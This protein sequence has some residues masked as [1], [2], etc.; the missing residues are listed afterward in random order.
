[1]I[2]IRCVVERITYQNPENGYSVLKCRVKDYSDLVPVVGN[3]LDANVGSVLLVEGN[4]KVD[5]KYGRQFVAENWEETLPATV[6]GM[7]KYLG[8][9]LIKGVGPKF[10]KK[11]VQK[12]GVDT[13]TVIEDNVDLLIEID[14]IGSK[15]VQM[16][17]E[18][19]L[20][21]KEVKN[22]MRDGAADGALL[23][24]KAAALPAQ[25]VIQTAVMLRQI[26]QDT[27]VTQTPVKLHQPFGGCHIDISDAAG[28]HHDLVGVL[29]DGGLDLIAE[30][31]D[32]GKEEIAAEAVDH[33][34]FDRPCRSIALQGIKIAMTRD[35][36]DKSCGR[37]DGADRGLPEGEHDTDDDA[38]QCSEEQYTEKSKEKDQPF[39]AVGVAQL[40][41]RPDLQD[42]D[43]RGGHDAGEH[44]HRQILKKRGTEHE[45]QQH[46]EAG[47]YG[48]QLGA[49]ALG[50]RY[51]AAGD[52]AVDG[53]GAAEGPGEIHGT[54][55]QEFGIV[56][57]G[58]LIFSCIIAGC[59]QCLG[60]DH[61]SDAQRLYQQIRKIG[62]KA[63]KTR[64]GKRQSLTGSKCKARKYGLWK[65]GGDGRQHLDAIPVQMK[66]NLQKSAKEHH[67]HGHG[68]LRKESFAEQDD[69]DGSH[70]KR[71]GK[72][73]EQRQLPH[74][75]GKQGD[76]LTRTR[77]ASKDF[78][79][80][81]RMMVSPTPD[82]KPPITGMEM[83]LTIRP[84][85]RK[86]STRN[87]RAVS[88]VMTGTSRRASSDSA[89]KPICAST[90]P[91][92]TAGMAS[93]P[94]TNC[95]EVVSRP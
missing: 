73:M 26:E 86:Y 35:A 18:S 20:K 15:R 47:G 13:F 54:V 69:Q 3:L 34:I 59:Q 81:I 49:H 57:E 66:E 72:G 53:A 40:A 85:F 78:G 56:I 6:Y 67:D 87:Q 25:P 63:C 22:I 60:H 27:A 17:A 2:K 64:Q 95:L 74:D 55:C 44:R 48:H 58:I 28:I 92:I 23:D 12:F 94:T 11:I 91:T 52:A 46:R 90:L 1:M 84:A 16:I 51:A 33:R 37:C 93:T 43:Q 5:A 19:W 31:I 88:S 21:Q 80:C 50:I 4:W 65:S 24:Q 75:I 79:T 39:A 41:F 7:E 10:A 32:I 70:P 30:K 36:A 68:D 82:I 71:K 62:G 9:G 76:Q 77:R 14:G 42:A 45:Q 83:Y 8:S 61:G 89:A 29:F 38:V